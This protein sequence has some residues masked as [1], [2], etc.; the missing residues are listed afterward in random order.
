MPVTGTSCAAGLP[1]MIRLSP[2]QFRPRPDA[3]R[4]STGN[5]EWA[6][7]HFCNQMTMVKQAEPRKGFFVQHEE[8]QKGDVGDGKQSGT[9]AR[10]R[11]RR[12]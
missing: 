3:A 11:G 7:C 1:N 4:Q 9:P 5:A 8:S 10:V 6:T 12:R 2:E